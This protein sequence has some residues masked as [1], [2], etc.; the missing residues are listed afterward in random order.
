MAE[1]IGMQIAGA[2]ANARLFDDL[3]KTEKSL[4]GE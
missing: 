4:T 2:I 3:S 1:R